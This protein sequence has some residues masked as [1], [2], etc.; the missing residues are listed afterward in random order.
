MLVG[1]GCA[2]SKCRSRGGKDS[3]AFFHRLD[4]M[5]ERLQYAEIVLSGAVMRN[6]LDRC[7]A[8]AE[9]HGLAARAVNRVACCLSYTLPCDLIY[10]IAVVGPDD[11]SARSAKRVV[12]LVQE[13]VCH[14]RSAGV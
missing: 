8:Q 13:T 5:G 4:W 14:G 9:E 6:G 2:L 10:R 11:A 7:R 12:E 3:L 1:A